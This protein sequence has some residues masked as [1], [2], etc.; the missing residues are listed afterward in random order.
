MGWTVCHPANQ[1]TTPT[2]TAKQNADSVRSAL[3]ERT[4]PR[5][6]RAD[7]IDLLFQF[8]KKLVADIAQSMRDVDA[9]ADFC[10]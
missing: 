4:R 10:E 5:Q 9:V 2:P 1:T 6:R 3:V 8:A 7:A